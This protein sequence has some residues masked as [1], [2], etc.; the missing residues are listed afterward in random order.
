MI[1]HI[2]AWLAP[3]YCVQ[4]GVA[5]YG[6]C[7][8]CKKSVQLHLRQCCAGCGMPLQEYCCPATHCTFYAIKQYIVAEYSDIVRRLLKQYKYEY[9]RA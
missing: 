4:C 9:R 7:K 2:I 3:H 8:V 1:E 5:G 6:L